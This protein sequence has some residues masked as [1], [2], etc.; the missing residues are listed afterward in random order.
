MT[1]YCD[2]GHHEKVFPSLLFLSWVSHRFVDYMEMHCGV[3][4]VVILEHVLTLT[5]S[6]AEEVEGRRK[7]WLAFSAGEEYEANSFPQITCY[8]VD[9]EHAATS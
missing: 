4:K 2:S 6:E 7:T 8:V 1:A 9:E 5:T 3:I